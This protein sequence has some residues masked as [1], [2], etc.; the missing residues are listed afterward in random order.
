MSDIAASLDLRDATL[1]Y[2]FPN[3]QALVYECHV[4]SL[5]RFERLIR[6]S[7]AFDGTGIAKIRHFVAALVEDSYVNGPQLYFGD[8][9]Y[10]E[11]L[12]RETIA[13]WAERSRAMLEGILIRGI[14]D[15]SIVPCETGPVVQLLLGMLI[16][17]AKW[18]PDVKGLTADRLMRA[19]EAFGFHGLESRP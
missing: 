18:A 1:Y 4:R 19:I 7:D 14:D 3:K 17:L 5:E 12:Q 13:I 8:Y 15:G 2:Y 6:E 16:W 10:L 11:P 9:S